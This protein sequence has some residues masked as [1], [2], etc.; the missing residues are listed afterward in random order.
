[1]PTV[2]ISWKPYM[3]PQRPHDRL[4][5]GEEESINVDPYQ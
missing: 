4:E 1:M 2:S 5:D 3:I